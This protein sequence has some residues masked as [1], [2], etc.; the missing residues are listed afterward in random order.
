MRSIAYNVATGRI[1]ES[2]GVRWTYLPGTNLKAS[3][4]ALA[5]PSPLS[6]K[7]IVMAAEGCIVTR[8]SLS[9]STTLVRL[10]GY[11]SKVEELHY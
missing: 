2:D 5:P 7:T 9:A 11:I 3:L 6:C 1:A 8:S 4:T 10:G